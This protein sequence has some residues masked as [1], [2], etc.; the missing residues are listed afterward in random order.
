[1]KIRKRGTYIEE[2]NTLLKNR[3]ESGDGIF[4]D[5]VI[6]DGISENLV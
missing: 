1:M 3:C 2:V 6:Y 5:V 4:I